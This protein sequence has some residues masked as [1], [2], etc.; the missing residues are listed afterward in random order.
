MDATMAAARAA[1][2]VVLVLGL[3]IKVCSLSMVARDRTLLVMQSECVDA[4][5]LI[6]A[7]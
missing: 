1:D 5:A 7:R 4:A 3:D 6:I 2:V